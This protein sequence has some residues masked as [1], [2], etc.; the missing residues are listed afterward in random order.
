MLKQY[1]G[2]VNAATNALMDSACPSNRA[3]SGV[4]GTRENQMGVAGRLDFPA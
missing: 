2:D 4:I 3:V 1:H